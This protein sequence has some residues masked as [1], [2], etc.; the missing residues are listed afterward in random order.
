MRMGEVIIKSCLYNLTSTNIMLIA[1]HGKLLVDV[2]EAPQIYVNNSAE[3]G[4]P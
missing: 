2:K 1:R 4:R 3:G